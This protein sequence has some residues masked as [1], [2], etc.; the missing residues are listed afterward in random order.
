MEVKKTVSTAEL[1]PSIS[2]LKVEMQKKGYSPQT[3][4]GLENVWDTLLCYASTVPTTSFDE[5]FREAFLR[6]EYGL[7]IDLE[8]TMYRVSR[9]LE[10]L[11]N[12][13]EFGVVTGFPKMCIRD[14][15]RSPPPRSQ[16]P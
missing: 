4:R 12:Y 3:M 13:I 16:T 15:S 1:L 14:R 9:A 2:A 11:K 8:Y 6:T 10:L 5:E 7:R